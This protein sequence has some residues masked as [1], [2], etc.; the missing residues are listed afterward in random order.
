MKRAS[1]FLKVEI[2]LDQGENPERIGEQICAQ[3]AKMYAV[4]RAEL[5]H[6]TDNAE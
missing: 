6:V 1:L 2:E 3:I 4:R 5:S